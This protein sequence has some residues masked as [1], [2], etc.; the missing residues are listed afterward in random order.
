MRIE[1][2]GS[3]IAPQQNAGKASQAASTNQSAASVGSSLTSI[4]VK[5]I[6]SILALVADTSSIRDTVVADVK[7]RIQTGE[8]LTKQSAVETANAILN[9]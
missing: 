9:L 1:N 2:S 8:Y 6:E 3:P 7:A 4:D 5:S